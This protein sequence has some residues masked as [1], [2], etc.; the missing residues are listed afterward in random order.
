[1]RFKSLGIDLEPKYDVGFDFM[2]RPDF[3]TSLS[4][5]ITSCQLAVSQVVGR[6]LVWMDTDCGP[7]NNADGR[8]LP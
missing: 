8:L 6:E 3:F 2:P 4:Q 7:S 1:M 5:L